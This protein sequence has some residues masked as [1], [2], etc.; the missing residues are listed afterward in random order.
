MKMA[1]QHNL[2]IDSWKEWKAVEFTRQYVN[3]SPVLMF[4]ITVVKKERNAN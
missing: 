4:N 3:S 2:L 1:S